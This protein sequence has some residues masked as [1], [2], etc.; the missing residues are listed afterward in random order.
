M[1]EQK[2]FTLIE[3]LVSIAILSIVLAAVGALMVTGSRSFAKGSADADIQKE[4]QL[5]VNQVEDLI[6]DTN[7][8]VDLQMYAAGTLLDLESVSTKAELDEK[9][10][11]ADKKELVLYNAV[12]ADTG[13]EY[14]KESVIWEKASEK[15]L[16]SKWKVSYNETED[17]YEI[18][19]TPLYENQLMAENVVSFSV[20]LLD[21][22]KEAMAD[23]TEVS[24][25]RSVQI[26][27]GYKS[28]NELVS[29]ATT[30][31][32]TLRNRLV[33]SNDP[34]LI[35]PSDTP[36]SDTLRLHISGTEETYQASVPI[37][38]GITEVECGKLYNIYAMVYQYDLVD[39]GGNVNE[40]VDFSIEE[41][42]SLSGISASG[43]LTVNELEP[44]DYLTIVAKYKDN[45]A[46]YAKG[47]VKVFGNS[48][49]KLIAAHII[50]D[51][52]PAFHPQYVSVVET[53]WFEEED[54]NALQYTWKVSEPDYFDSF[55]GTKDSLKLSVNQLNEEAYGKT[56]MITLEVY[57][58]TINQRVTDTVQYT[59]DEKGNSGDSNMVRAGQHEYGFARRDVRT[60]VSYYFCDEQGNKLINQDGIDEYITV[61]DDHWGTFAVNVSRDIPWDRDYNLRVLA[62]V[63]Q[64]GEI[65][66]DK[67]L[68]IESVKVY[69]YSSVANDSGSYYFYISSCVHDR[70]QS[71]EIFDITC[72]EV[73]TKDGNNADVHIN[74][75]SRVNTATVYPEPS[76]LYWMQGQYS[77]VGNKENIQSI[78]LKI[79]LKEYPDI[80]TY[81]TVVFH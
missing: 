71:F 39:W 53:E 76:G 12:T 24:V 1:K 26:T 62:T 20:D 3:V 63:D 64:T 61:R 17:I 13:T 77:V 11:L 52:L 48:R 81:S 15:V 9:D 56:V 21:V 47:I 36:D 66:Y 50:P 18:D 27:A 69:P 16:Y 5:V 74:I 65:V 72:V 41:D 45:P 22:K 35:F 7:G 31:L 70:I 33:K 67:I 49:K 59:I 60:T 25:L 57:A 46:K 44:N 78:K 73:V 30:P 80:Y 14:T 42:N 6:I 19:G 55:D 4:A 75:I 51:K 68:A 79:A 10:A 43:L 37:I 38:D 8:G 29:Y 58:P 34:E 32:I 40:Y 28:G 2:G 23:G 54:T